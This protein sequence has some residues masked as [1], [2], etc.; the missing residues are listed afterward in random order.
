MVRLNL[1]LDNVRNCEETARFV[2]EFEKILSV[3]KQGLLF[4]K[5][6]EPDQYEEM[7]KEK[8]WK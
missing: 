7:C 3:S 8:W 2:K 4:E 1:N 5:F 6:K